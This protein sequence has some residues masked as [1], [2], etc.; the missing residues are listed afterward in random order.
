M[1]RSNESL[2]GFKNI[3]KFLG[4]PS[5]PRFTGSCSLRDI[6]YIRYMNNVPSH[7]GVELFY[8]Y[9]LQDYGKVLDP[10]SL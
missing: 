6:R 7:Q 4:V 9:L 2:Y 5:N 10:V 8:S 1:L 3:L